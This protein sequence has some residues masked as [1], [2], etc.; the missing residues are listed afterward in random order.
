MDVTLETNEAMIPRRSHQKL[1][2]R[3]V[4]GFSRLNS[5]VRRMHVSLKVERD[6]KGEDKI[7]QIQLFLDN[8][9]QIVIK[10]KGRRFA[11]AMAASIRRARQLLVQQSAR[12][13][14]FR[15]E[16]MPLPA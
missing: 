10:Q 7:C 6:Q 5:A 9:S 14:R 16:A 12:K 2:R 4:N 1:A 13:R 8:G 15:R 3:F 11:K